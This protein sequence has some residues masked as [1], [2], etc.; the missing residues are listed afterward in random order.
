VYD[1]GVVSSSGYGDGQYLLE[2]L[3]EGDLIHGFKITF[4]DERNPFYEDEE[5]YEDEWAD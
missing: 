1:T 4:I 3:E 2:V 5:E